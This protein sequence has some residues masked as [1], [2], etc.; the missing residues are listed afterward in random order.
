[1]IENIKWL[2]HGGFLIQGPP[3]IYINPW[4]VVRT[5]FHADVILVGHDHY[6]HCSIADINKLRGPETK[7]VGNER[8]AQQ[9]EDATVIRP[10]QSIAFERA[11]VKAVPAYSPNQVQHPQEHGGLGFII[12]INYHDIYYAGD[13]KIIP[14]MDRI[15]Q[16]DIVILPIDDDGTLSIEEAVDVVKK[17]RPQWVIP[18]N[19]GAAGE[20][21]SQLDMLTFKRLVSQYAEFIIPSQDDASAFAID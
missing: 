16:P 10:W 19:W 4:R 3:F 11:S 17:L 5:A 12:S 21:A 1:M 14:E 20:G 15:Q 2:G 7:I 13:T 6:D 9:I 8:V 18:C